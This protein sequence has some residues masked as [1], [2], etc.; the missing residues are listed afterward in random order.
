MGLLRPGRAGANVCWFLCMNR[1]EV[2]VVLDELA[3]AALTGS[4]THTS[5]FLS[6]SQLDDLFGKLK[7]HSKSNTTQSI[8]IPNNTKQHSGIQ[9]STTQH[10]TTGQNTTQHNSRAIIYSRSTKKPLKPLSPF[11]NTA[12]ISAH[13]A[14]QHSNI[15]I[16]GHLSANCGSSASLR[17][18]RV[19]PACR[20][21]RIDKHLFSTVIP[22]SCSFADCGPTFTVSRC[23]LPSGFLS[24][25][26]QRTQSNIFVTL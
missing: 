23:G 12:D 24:Y 11:R 10:G 4:W 20:K 3:V 1:S 6:D 7:L 16:R 25:L 2:T 19:E 5:K 18:Y 13:T 8:S 17:T 14:V 21:S 15:R 22:S 26:G 9:Q